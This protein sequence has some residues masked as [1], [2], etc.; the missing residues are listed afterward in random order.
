M[1]RNPRPVK[2]DFVLEITQNISAS[3]GSGGGS[4]VELSDAIPQ[5]LGV[6]AAGVGTN[7][8]TPATLAVEPIIV[9]GVNGSPIG[10]GEPG[11]D[12][13]P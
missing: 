12:R 6:A 3:G 1:P 5:D 10:P 9:A 4:G 8:A 7:P 13:I 2:K 11:A